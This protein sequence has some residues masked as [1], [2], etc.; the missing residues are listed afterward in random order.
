M[1][2]KILRET[3]TV[4]NSV[5]IWDWKQSDVTTCSGFHRVE[6][7]KVLFFFLLIPTYQYQSGIYVVDIRA[8]LIAG[9]CGASWHWK[10]AEK[11]PSFTNFGGYI[12]NVDSYRSTVKHT[13]LKPDNLEPSH[14][15]TSGDEIMTD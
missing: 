9:Q 12:Y 10:I 1:K 11:K 6:K 13:A 14:H 4:G 2:H 8:G 5:R 3:N 15:L 7:N